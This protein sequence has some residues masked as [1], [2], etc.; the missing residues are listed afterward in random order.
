MT[1][2]KNDDLLIFTSKGA[3]CPV[4]DFYIDPVRKVK[5]A[6]I[7]HAHADHARW[8]MQKYLGHKHNE[9][10][11]RIRIDKNID[12][13]GIEYNEKLNIN[14]VYVTFLPAGHIPGSAMILLEHKGQKWCFSGDYKVED[15][16]FSTPIQI[17]KCNT[18][19]T[20]ST[21]GLPIFDWQAQDLI[22][23]ELR[24]WIQN[25]FDKGNSVVLFAYSL[26]KAQ[27]LLKNLETFKDKT[28]IHRSIYLLNEALINHGY[29]IGNYETSIENLNQP[30]LLIVP[31]A[32]SEANALRRLGKYST[33]CAS[34]WMALRGAKR[35][36]NYNKGFVL[37]DHTDWK[38]ILKTIKETEAEN[39]M[40]THGYSDVLTKY[41][42]EIGYNAIDLKF[43]GF[44]DALE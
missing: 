1:R 13:T 3:Y 24:L 23:E 20:E 8:G 35:R 17:P 26:G 38:G 6:L 14:G 30:V 39:I 40:V 15:D 34:G 31:P 42:N 9:D 44:D 19:I 41:L 12:F 43:S 16:G 36:S 21:F 28:V 18:F 5:N 33:A 25:E 27:R 37:S 10:I 29:S 22:F 7:T 2:R 11:L 32:A 4:G